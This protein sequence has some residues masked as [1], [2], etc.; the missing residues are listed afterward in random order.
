[1]HHHP[2]MTF[3][4]NPCTLW[5]QPST[6]GH[7]ARLKCEKKPSVFGQ[8]FCLEK[9]TETESGKL[10]HLGHVLFW[11]PLCPLCPLSYL[12]GSSEWFMSRRMWLPSCDPNHTDLSPSCFPCD[13]GDI[14]GPCDI[15]LTD[16]ALYS[17]SI[18]MRGVS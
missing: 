9:S 18:F 1:M 10:S 12:H 11:C 3:R 17:N 16:E 14:F 7:S 4:W 6:P 13:V 2:V 8:S 5:V 15:G